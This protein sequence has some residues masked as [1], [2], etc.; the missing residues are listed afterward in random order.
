[1]DKKEKIKQA[2]IDYVLEHKT[3][4]KSVLSFTKKLKLKESEFYEYYNSFESIDRSVWLTFF[5]ETILK[6]ESDEIYFNYSV[7][8]KL[9]AFY[10]TLIEVL[11]ENRSFIT[12][13]IHKLREKP[14]KSGAFLVDFKTSFIVFIKELLAEGKESQEII[15][16]KFISDKYPEVFWGQLLLVLYFWA[17]DESTS[18][19]KTDTLIEKAVNTSFDVMGS[20]VIDSVLDFAKFL[21][22]NR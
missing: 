17:K 18:F 14:L 9:L 19:E 1:M 8:E 5:E 2:Y 11:K 7:R 10:Y 3:H 16:R 12:Y 4:P 15:E 20:S 21:I 6:L 13:S 22:Q